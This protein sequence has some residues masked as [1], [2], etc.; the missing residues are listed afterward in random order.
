[1]VSLK[2]SEASFFIQQIKE[3][4]ERTPI[5]IIIDYLWGHPVEMILTAFQHTAYHPVKLVT[6]GQMAGSD[7]I[8]PQRSLEVRPLNYWVPE[9]AAFPEVS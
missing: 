7:I 3:I 2:E 8:L 1:M 6:V 5:D 4:N 9:S